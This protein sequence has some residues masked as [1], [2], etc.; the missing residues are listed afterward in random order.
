MKI[1]SPLNL[2]RNLKSTLFP[3]KRFGWKPPKSSYLLQSQ[4]RIGIDGIDNYAEVYQAAKMDHGPLKT[5]D[6][7]DIRFLLPP[8]LTHPSIGVFT[9]RRGSVCFPSGFALTSS[10]KLIGN[11]SRYGDN[12]REMRLDDDPSNC[13]RVELSGKSLSLATEFSSQNYGHFLLDGI[14]RLSIFQKMNSKIFE[15]HDR[16]FISGPEAQWKKRLLAIFKVP[17]GKILWLDRKRYVCEELTV[18]SFPGV[19]QSY[20]H[21][22]CEFFKN[23][24]AGLDG[25]TQNPRRLFISRSG[26]SRR[27][28]NEQELYT[29]AEA[30]GFELY[31][32]ERSENPIG[33]FRN[34]D[35]VIGSHGAGLTDIVFMA[36]G[37]RVLELMPTDHRHCYFF[38]LGQA[39]GLDYTVI[40][41]ESDRRR[42]SG[43]WGPSPYD[44]QIAPSIFARYLEA[45]F[46]SLKGS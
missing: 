8:A 32:P 37:S 14:G 23:S 24:M 43:S 17:P 13:E 31:W 20:P 45:K 42:P 40:L 6:G 34:A 21:W 2:A 19:R 9:L 46:G 16:I 25:P 41:G 33:D 30:Y 22:L 26:T 36:R 1:P 29:A 18:S 28:K 4:I 35:A 3:N 15:M 12:R 38:T 7:N 10:G 39:S 5:F 27:L 11:A 44:F